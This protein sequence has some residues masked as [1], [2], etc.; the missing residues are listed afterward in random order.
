MSEQCSGDGLVRVRLVANWDLALELLIPGP[1]TKRVT[2]EYS[3]YLL[4]ESNTYGN[5]DVRRRFLAERCGVN[6]IAETVA[7]TSSGCLESDAES[8]VCALEKY[9]HL[10]VDLLPSIH[11]RLW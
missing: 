2:H 10:Q 1:L 4:A 6:R 7:L 9:G 5:T 11:G 8:P 3:H